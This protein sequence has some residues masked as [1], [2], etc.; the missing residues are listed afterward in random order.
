MNDADSQLTTAQL[1][2]GLIGVS[3]M[4][5]VFL[6]RGELRPVDRWRFA[7]IVLNGMLVAFGAFVPIW[8]S[9]VLGDSD[10]MWR[11]VWL[12]CCSRFRRSDTR[13]RALLY[14]RTSALYRCWS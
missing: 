2:V 11:T 3:A 8:T 14:A 1:A 12:P 6:S 13:M 9:Y 5:S 10:R 7:M 4:V